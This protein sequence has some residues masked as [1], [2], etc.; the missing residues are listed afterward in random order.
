MC[1][2]RRDKKPFVKKVCAACGKVLK[3]GYVSYEAIL[4]RLF[5][6]LIY[7]GLFIA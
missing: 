1:K 3:C 4:R 7:S 2:K 5:I 6:L